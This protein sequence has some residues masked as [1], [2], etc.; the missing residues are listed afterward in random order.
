MCLL[1]AIVATSTDSALSVHNAYR[2]V[3]SAHAQL[4]SLCELVKMAVKI[5]NML[6]IMLTTRRFGSCPLI[7]M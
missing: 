7:E 3:L 1:L 2:H 4:V 5:V 6:F